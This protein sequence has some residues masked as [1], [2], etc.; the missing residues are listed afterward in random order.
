MD[1][2]HHHHFSHMV[3]N[4]FESFK[5]TK[6]WQ[7]TDK[8]MIKAVYYIQKSCQSSKN[9]DFFKRELN[10]F[11]AFLI[12]RIQRQAVIVLGLRTKSPLYAK[13]LQNQSWTFTISRDL[14][15]LKRLRGIWWSNGGTWWL[16]RRKIAIGFSKPPILQYVL[17]SRI[18]HIPSR[19][20]I[21]HFVKES[22]L[23]SDCVSLNT[24]RCSEIGRR[25][26]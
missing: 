12:K 26:G 19:K 20:S 11:P 4:D 21:F 6:T 5:D 13:C 10:I 7:L 18:F 9:F 22:V 23:L 24:R 15:F 1:L 16:Q 8:F 17:G 2:R 14:L 3:A 25:Y